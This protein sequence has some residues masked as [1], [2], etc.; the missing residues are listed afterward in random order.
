MPE[1]TVRTFRE[2]ELIIDSDDPG[3]R[4]W[5]RHKCMVV[6]IHK[7]VLKKTLISFH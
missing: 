1:G 6:K 2:E 4:V 7:P 5:C 3:S